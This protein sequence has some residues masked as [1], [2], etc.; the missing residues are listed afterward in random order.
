MILN[1]STEEDSSSIAN[2]R[3]KTLS[4]SFGSMKLFYEKQ[5]IMMNV[6]HIISKPLFQ[7]SV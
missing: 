7:F 3:V 2:T 4:F 1:H 5:F 6:K